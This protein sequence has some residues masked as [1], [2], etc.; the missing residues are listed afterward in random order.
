MSFGPG[1]DL[2]DGVRL[3]NFR[4]PTRKKEEEKDGSK[5]V[6]EERK[7]RKRKETSLKPMTRENKKEIKRRKEQWRSHSFF[8]E[9]ANY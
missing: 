9:G 3:A 7:E 2:A 4:G 1:P 6:W 8:N 5:V